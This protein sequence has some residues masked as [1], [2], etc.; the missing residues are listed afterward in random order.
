[1]AVI[2]PQTIPAAGGQPTY[3]ACN[4]GGDSIPNNG[5][6][7]LL[8]KNTSG[9]ALH[10]TLDSPAVDNF[11]VSGSALDVTFT[12]PAGAGNAGA[13]PFITPDMSTRR[14]NDVNNRVQLT[15]PDGI[16]GLSVAAV[17]A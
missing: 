1:M 17:Y 8:F 15:Y 2:N 12:V 9:G 6:V 7:K 3:T 5:A 16:T 4:V 11:G 10:V 14:F 13:M